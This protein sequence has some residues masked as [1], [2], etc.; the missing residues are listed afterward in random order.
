M[1]SAPLV[2]LRRALS[3]L[4][5]HVACS[6]NSSTVLLCIPFSVQHIVSPLLPKWEQNGEKMP[7]VEK[8]LGVFC[9]IISYVHIDNV[10]FEKI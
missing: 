2:Q 4:R 8:K 10:N 1:L 9:E 3:A 5:K 6:F 7:P